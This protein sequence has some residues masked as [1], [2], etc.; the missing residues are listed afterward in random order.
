MSN[1]GVESSVIQRMLESEGQAFVDGRPRVRLLP[2]EQNQRNRGASRCRGWRPLRPSN[3]LGR[4]RRRSTIHRCRRTMYIDLFGDMSGFCGHAP[5]PVVAAVTRAMAKGN[6]FLL[7]GEDAIVV[8]EELA[9]DTASV[10]AV[11]TVCDD[12]ERRGA[13]SR[14]GV[15]TARGRCGVRRQVPRASR[16][17][18]GCRR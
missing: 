2:H 16:L 4:S 12:G 14:T 11:H 8:S 15:H 13:S 1:S 17:D 9:A 18:L 5:P 7:P 6:Q 10:L 3:G